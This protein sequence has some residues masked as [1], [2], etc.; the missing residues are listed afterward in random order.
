MNNEPIKTAVRRRR[1]QER[2]GRLNP[3]CVI[4]GNGNLETLAEVTPEWLRQRVPPERL[5][6]LHHVFGQQS[7]P[8]AVIPVCMNCHRSLTERLA[9]A[10]IS[11]R[12]PNEPREFVALM[13]DALALFFESLV[14]ALRRW[15]VYLRNSIASEATK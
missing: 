2:F 4:C 10:G 9:Q 12:P 1:K 3:I 13:L 15:A 7:E 14:E 8:R 6:E 5:I 11:M